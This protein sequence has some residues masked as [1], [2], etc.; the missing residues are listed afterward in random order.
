MINELCICT[1]N[2]HSVLVVDCVDEDIYAE[3]TAETHL[4]SR[5][6]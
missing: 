3:E 6:R 4:P 1:H 5:R 2:T